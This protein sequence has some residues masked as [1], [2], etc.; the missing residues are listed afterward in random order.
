MTTTLDRDLQRLAERAVARAPLGKAQAALVAM[1]PDGQ[2]VAMVGGKNYP[3]SPFN[4]AT[5][6]RRQP[7]SAF[8]LFVYLAA[9][10]SGWTPDSMIDDAPI[11]IDGWTPLNSDRRLSRAND[12]ARSLRPVEQCRD[13]AA[14]AAVGLDNVIRAARDL[15]ITTPLPDKPSLALGTA[16]VSLL[17]LTS[18]YAAVAS[19]RYPIAARGL[20]DA[21]ADRPRRLLPPRRD[22]RRRARPNADAR[23]PLR[24]GE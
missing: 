14:V 15:G 24:C 3:D 10:R 19:G 20:P 21:G 7:G 22:A 4:R 17:E 23:P 11:T 2:V 18:A 1:R 12:P 8:K 5:Q 9:M 13:G 16:S 6:A